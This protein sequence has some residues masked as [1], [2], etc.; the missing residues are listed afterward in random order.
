MVME[1]LD[2]PTLKA[3]LSERRRIGQ[4]FDPQEAARILTPIAD[5]VDYAHSQGMIH[6]DLKP[7]NIQ[8]TS[9]GQPILTDFGISKIVGATRFTVTGAVTGTPAYMSPEQGQGQ[10]VDERSDI[11]SLGVILYEMTTG[12]VP[13]DADT[14]YAIIMKHISD[15]LPLPR[16]VFPQLPESVERVILKTLSKNPDDRYQTA[17]ELVRALEQALAAPAVPIVST[18]A[19]ARPVVRP[20]EAKAAAPVVTAPVLEK[21]PLRLMPLLVG[22]GL[23]L[24]LVVGV[25]LSG[26]IP[27]LSGL[28]RE[29]K[30]GISAFVNMALSYW[31]PLTLTVFALLLWTQR[32]TI[33]F[34][35][36]R[37]K[38]ILV[39]LLSAPPVHERQA[40]QSA[41]PV[42][43]PP[44]APEAK[45]KEAILPEVSQPSL[46]L[47]PDVSVILDPLEKSTIQALVAHQESERLRDF[48][49]NFR[50]GRFLL[51]GYGSFGGT[52]LTQ[53][54]IESAKYSL[55]REG[56]QGVL[57]AIRFDLHDSSEVED[58]FKVKVDELFL[59]FLTEQHRYTPSDGLK[60]GFDTLSFV[61]ASEAGSPK[62]ALI[63]SLGRISPEENVEIFLKD[64]KAVLTGQPQK[65]RLQETI[66]QVLGS[67]EP[68]SRVLIILDKVSRPEILELFTHFSLFDD[69]RIA[70]IAIIE[71]EQYDR[72]DEKIKT[73][74]TRRKRFKEWY[75][76]C[77]WESESGFVRRVTSLLFEDRLIE[78][79]E[80]REMR[81]ALQ[82]HLAFIGRGTVGG[83]IEELRDP[84]YWKF[85]SATGR[86]YISFDLLDKGLIHHNAWLQNTLEENWDKI[87]GERFVGRDRIDRA[88][89]GIYHLLDW[90][91][92]CGIFTRAEIHEAAE[93][94]IVVISP[95]KRPRNGVINDLL[96]VLVA[97]GYL[98]EVKGR[99]GIVWG[100]DIS[101]E[102]AL[103]EVKLGDHEDE[104]SLRKQLQK[105][106]RNRWKLLDKTATFAKGQVPL[107]LD[108]QLEEV[109]ETISQIKEKLSQYG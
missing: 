54:V 72:W 109:E 33:A 5:A 64:L 92:D 58:V 73:R 38:A 65:S 1:F 21:R 81:Q 94:T 96:Q 106:E 71:R 41:H 47:K 74:L 13:Y 95:H 3:E 24:A 14:P 17:A 61:P 70:Y 68:P 82:S 53:E 12:R 27:I 55:Q 42:D 6:R 105:L 20:Q 29:A 45:A 44:Y 60:A 50:G 8:F 39:S 16:Q 66:F 87:L 25:L 32:G 62:K 104:E 28:W 43:L 108:N 2:G 63:P 97:N 99:Y 51:T 101:T 103:H 89:Q 91:I 85:D 4:P 15:P 57:L 26:G 35:V 75:V 100:R 67:L 88:K 76:P 84:K 46:I 93:Q 107:Y 19:A 102:E 77:N 10:S 7:A 79:E 30:L 83:T 59:G 49:V 9:G 80:A 56:E 86:G 69:E 78:D 18:E 48:I 11:Y 36:G 31:L 22:G 37:S 52:T 34:A 23:L 40:P 98:D 90:I